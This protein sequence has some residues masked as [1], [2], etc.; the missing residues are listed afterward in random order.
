[1]QNAVERALNQIDDKNYA[2]E[3]KIAG[4]KEIIKVGI[5]FC[6]KEVSLG[7]RNEVFKL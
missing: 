6:G 2:D 5:T 7:Y 1:M 3:L 4:I